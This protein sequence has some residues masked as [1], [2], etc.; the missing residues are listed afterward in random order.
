NPVQT[1]AWE[2]LEKHYKETA[3]S[4]LREL[5]K[6]PNRFQKFHIRF[7]DLLLDYSKNLIDD[8]TMNLLIELAEDCKLNSA[9]EKMFTGDR[10]NET[11]DRAV[12]HTGLRNRSNQPVIVDGKDVMPE[13][14]SVLN[15]MK[16]FSEKVISGE[17]K[18][19]SGKE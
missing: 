3:G 13:I 10:I 6:D 14:N 19:F 18:G 4:S 17:W 8:E 2:K 15:Q 1:K 7:D 16:L 9:I 11:E 5:F 12:L